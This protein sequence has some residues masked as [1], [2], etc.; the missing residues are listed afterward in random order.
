MIYIYL[1][2]FLIFCLGI[3]LAMLIIGWG[4]TLDARQWQKHVNNKVMQSISKINF[5]ITKIY[6]LTDYN[7]QLKEDNLK[8][9]LL[10][11]NE[12]EK[13]ALVD[14]V[15]AKLIIVD[16]KDLLDFELYENEFKFSS[17]DINLDNKRHVGLN[18]KTKNRVKKLQLV[19][20]I[21][22][23]NKTQINYDLV[24]NSFLNLGIIKE[25][26]AFKTI[27]K[28]LQAVVLFFEEVKNKT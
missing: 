26:M 16:Y 22:D 9:M 28:D 12:N 7:T 17:Q 6:Y 23:F 19:V 24:S 27:I 25:S 5:T 3:L 20:N 11:D 18:E 1:E 14:Y 8:K 4:H 2:V 13:F 15:N 10:V 21:N